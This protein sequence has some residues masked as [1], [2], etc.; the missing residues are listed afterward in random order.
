[1]TINHSFE[2]SYVMIAFAVVG[3]IVIGGLLAAMHR[4]HK[5][6]PNLIGALI[7]ALLCFLL[8]EALPALT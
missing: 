3:V 8:I 6:H 5:Y 1:M 4:K 2:L 7:G